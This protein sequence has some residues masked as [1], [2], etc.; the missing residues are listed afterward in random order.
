MPNQVDIQVRVDGAQRAKADLGKISESTNNMSAQFGAASASM[1]EMSGELSGSMGAASG[2]IAAMAMGIDGLKAASEAGKISMMGLLGPIGLIASAIAGTVFS[3]KMMYDAMAGAN[4]E[5]EKLKA[6]IEALTAGFEEFLSQ[7]I[8]LSRVELEALTRAEVEYNFHKEALAEAQKKTIEAAQREIDLRSKLKDAVEELAKVEEAARSA[9]RVQGTDPVSILAAAYDT[10]SRSV[11]DATGSV[12]QLN[13]EIAETRKELETL[14]NDRS[15]EGLSTAAIEA[16]D[17]LEALRTEIMKR[18]KDAREKSAADEEAKR[19]TAA[20]KRSAAF[21]KVL[22]DEEALRKK[23]MILRI[24]LIEHEENRALASVIFAHNEM[25][26]ELDKSMARIGKKREA[27][28][29]IAR[30]RDKETARIRA[31]F[32][33][34]LSAELAAILDQEET[35]RVQAYTAR[36]QEITQLEQQIQSS[37][38]RSINQFVTRLDA[39]QSGVSG[40]LSIMASSTMR[41]AE[42]MKSAL[43]DLDIMISGIGEGLAAS[44]VD[45]LT[46]GESFESMLKELAKSTAREAFISGLMETAKGIGRLAVGD[47]AGSAAHF[48][49]AAVYATVGGVATGIAGSSSGGGS[50][51]PAAP[52]PREPERSTFEREVEDTRSTT[53]NINFAG[54]VYDSEYAA[55]QALAS[56]VTRAINNKGRGR[57]ILKTA[58]V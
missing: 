57:P 5:A 9:R 21:Q 43:G 29:L 10:T 20:A 19:K 53:I 35:A 11:L 23:S 32:A 24:S 27:M 25:E 50:G 7:A 16:A 13:K 48:K 37:A 2:S 26:R 30:S 17:R 18:G 3:F 54:D 36:L 44:A 6:T 49:A 15:V 38:E 1:A 4:E 39:L 14:R 45:A 8:R 31:E 56:R 33:E 28:D 58:R 40:T 46:A 42:L 55:S 41:S 12:N 51:A 47:L 22:A 34:R 52:P